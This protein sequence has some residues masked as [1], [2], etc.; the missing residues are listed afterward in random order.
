M[1]EKH[2]PEP[3]S[4]KS[5]IPHL[6]L[7]SPP[8]ASPSHTPTPS[9]ISPTEASSGGKRK[10]TSEI[11][12]PP[13]SE[14]PQPNEGSPG[15]KGDTTTIPAKRQKTKT[16]YGYVGKNGEILDKPPSADGLEDAETPKP[17]SLEKG[18]GRRKRTE[19][20]SYRV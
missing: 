18:R 1:E 12:P 14:S 19:V 2:S 5:P 20:K 4:P 16:W 11:P 13:D 15:P 8:T 3:P 10:R 9:E 7:D 6:G 17:P